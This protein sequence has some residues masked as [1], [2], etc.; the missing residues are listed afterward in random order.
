MILMMTSTSGTFSALLALCW[1]STGH[2]GFSHKRQWGEALMFSLTCAGAMVEP[3]NNR[4]AGDLR[5]HCDIARYD[6]TGIY[7]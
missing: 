2:G 6:V 3:E 5:R 7:D 1:E 4:D